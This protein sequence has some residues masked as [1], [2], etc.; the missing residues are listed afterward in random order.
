[1]WASLEALESGKFIDAFAFVRVYIYVCMV[2][3]VMTHT[4]ASKP[5][6][7]LRF[8]ICCRPREWLFFR[9]DDAK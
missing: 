1:M 5:R 8:N 4:R 6:D 3:D 7:G 9:C 2:A